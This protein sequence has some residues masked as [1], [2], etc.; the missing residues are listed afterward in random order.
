M[1][2]KGDS[3]V[4]QLVAGDLPPGYGKGA[5]KDRAFHHQNQRTL[6]VST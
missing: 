1:S 2:K 5:G 4:G 6:A 3:E